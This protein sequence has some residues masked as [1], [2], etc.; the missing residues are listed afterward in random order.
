MG[1]PADGAVVRRRRRQLRQFDVQHQHLLPE[2]PSGTGL[3]LNA[4]LGNFGVTTM[5]IVIPLVMTVGMFGALGGA[6]ET[7]LN[8][9]GWIFG[10]IAAGTPTWIQNAGFAWCSPGAAGRAVLVR[11]EQPEDDLARHRQPDRRLRED[12]LPLYGG[13]R[14]VDPDALPVPPA[15]TGLGLLNMWVAIPLDIILALLVMK[16]CRL[17]RDEG[18][19]R[20]AVRHL[21][22]QTPGR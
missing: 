2:A 10:K 15:P 16:S 18:G 5:Q 7:L 20:Q 19:R 12:H 3:G 13:L 17:R 21:P 4:G 1:F 14:A 11:H 8:D 22:Q 6:P 9:S